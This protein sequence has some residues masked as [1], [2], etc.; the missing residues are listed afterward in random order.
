MKS[1]KP[2]NLLNKSQL[3]SRFRT[4]LKRDR[5]FI[6]DMIDLGH[7]HI[8]SYVYLKWDNELGERARSLFYER[9]AFELECKSRWGDSTSLSVLFS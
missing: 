8:S 9:L 4:H 7:G 5:K 2:L 6:D 1:L 3:R